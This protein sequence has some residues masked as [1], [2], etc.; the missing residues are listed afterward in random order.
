MPLTLMDKL[1]HYVGN[2]VAVKCLRA[3]NAQFDMAA[4]MDPTLACKLHGYSNLNAMK[5][6]IRRYA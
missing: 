6:Q 1:H 5:R 3:Y 4:G 2:Y